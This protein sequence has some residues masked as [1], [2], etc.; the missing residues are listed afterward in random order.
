MDEE[1]LCDVTIHGITIVD[2]KPN[3]NGFAI[4]AFFDCE[5]FGLRL[6]GCALMRTPKRGLSVSPPRLEG[7]EAARRS[8]RITSDLI[9]NAMLTSARKA[10]I[11]LG[12]K[13][14]EWEPHSA[15]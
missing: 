2:G 5:T 9:R 6:N 11:A 13:E 7:P 15:A 14:A 8:V 10:Y 12:G 4:L 1:Y 3:A